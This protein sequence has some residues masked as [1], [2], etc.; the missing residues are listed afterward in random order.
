MKECAD[1]NDGEIG[2]RRS[3]VSM[4]LD[5]AGHRA[6]HVA[7]GALDFSELFG[8]RL[9]APGDRPQQRAHAHE[10]ALQIVGNHRYHVAAL[11]EQIADCRHVRKGPLRVPEGEHG[12]DRAER[13]RDRAPLVITVRNTAS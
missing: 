6:V 5:Q 13:K 11:V 2:P 4:R 10:R 9:R 3:I 7:A 1:L 12:G 8:F